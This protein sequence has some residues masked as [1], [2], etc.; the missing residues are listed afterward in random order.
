MRKSG[1]WMSIWDDRILEYIL[2]NNTGYATEIANDEHVHV[3][4][5]HISRRLR[6]LSD[7]GLLS[8]GKKGIYSITTEGR[9]YLAGAYDA[10]EG[11]IIETEL[12]NYE[13]VVLESEEKLQ[14]L[15]SK[16]EKPDILQ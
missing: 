6:E 11:K 15:R 13:W 3:S 2:D 16:W 12:R 1:S 14:A 8:E 10:E 9:Y 4:Q 7:Q 5:Q